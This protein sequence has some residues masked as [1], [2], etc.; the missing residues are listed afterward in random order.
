[1]F[2]IIV[3]VYFQDRC[4]IFICLVFGA[5]KA[6]ERRTAIEFKKN[7]GEATASPRIS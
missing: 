1:M 4:A 6:R 5:E 7:K 3:L 2:E